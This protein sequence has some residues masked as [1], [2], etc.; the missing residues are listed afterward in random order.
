MYRQRAGRGPVADNARL[1]AHGCR[2]KRS[3]A[4]TAVVR[5]AVFQSAPGDGSSISLSTMST[6]AVEDVVLIGDVVV[7]RHRLDPERLTELPHAERL[8]ARFIGESDRGAEH[9]VPV[10]GGARFLRRCPLRCQ[11]SGVRA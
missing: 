5:R 9:P 8:D 2:S 11:A 3:W 4:E 6:I 7:Q 10:Q 1:A